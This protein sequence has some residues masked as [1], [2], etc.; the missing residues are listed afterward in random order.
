METVNESQISVVVGDTGSGKS[1]Q[2][3]Q[4]L[5]EAGYTKGRKKIGFT[6]PRRVAA[7]SVAKHVAEERGCRLGEEVGYSIRLEECTSPETEI[8]YMTDGMLLREILLDSDLMSYSVIILDEAH[9]RTI[10]TDNYFDL[11]RDV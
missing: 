2:M 1:T 3:T 9:K 4:Y 6:Q 11:S 7:I 5:C 10:A 8:N